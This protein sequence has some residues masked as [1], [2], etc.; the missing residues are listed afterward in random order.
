MLP[1]LVLKIWSTR[2]WLPSIQRPLLLNGANFCKESLFLIG[3]VASHA[4]ITFWLEPTNVRIICDED[5]RFTE[6]EKLVNTIDLNRHEAKLKKKK[7]EIR[8][9]TKRTYF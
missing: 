7:K 5:C 2:N 9:S 8:E 6:S 4:G 3:A 1:F